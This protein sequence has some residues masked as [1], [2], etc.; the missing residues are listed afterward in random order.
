M[1]SLYL[2]CVTVR[3]IFHCREYNGSPGFHTYLPYNSQSQSKFTPRI[4]KPLFHYMI[5]E[6][7]KQTTRD[8]SVDSTRPCTLTTCS[9]IDNLGKI[10]SLECQQIRITTKLNSCAFKTKVLGAITLRSKW[11]VGIAL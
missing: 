9:L 11:K 3:L 2:I 8:L 1:H 4:T 7:V 6:Y 10:L 5:H